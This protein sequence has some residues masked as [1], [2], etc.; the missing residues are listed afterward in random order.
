MNQI[1]SK[2]PKPVTTHVPKATFSSP[3]P[4]NLDQKLEDMANKVGKKKSLTAIHFKIEEALHRDMKI[5][6]AK[7]GET[8]INYIQAL[9]RADL[10]GK[11]KSH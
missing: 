1:K 7:R 10:Y 2:K 11:N 8:M 5:E 6:L 9:I 4:E 3:K